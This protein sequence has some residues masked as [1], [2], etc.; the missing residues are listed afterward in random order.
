MKVFLRTIALLALVSWLGAC[1]SL[2]F[3][4][5]YRIK[6][7][8]GNYLEK[9]MVDQLEVGLTRTQVRYVMGTPLVEDT[10]TPNRWDYYFH[11]RHGDKELAEY[12]MTMLFDGDLLTEWS[13]NYE[14]SRK[15]ALEREREAVEEA[16]KKDDAKFKKSEEQRF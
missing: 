11:V 12:H 5:V 6:I 15:N 9:E 7:T 2:K 10:F 1:S 13:G 4:G 3:P 8:Q 16:K 14:P